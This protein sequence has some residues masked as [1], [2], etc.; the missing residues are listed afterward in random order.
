M[1]PAGEKLAQEIMDKQSIDIDGVSGATVTSK[2]AK[3]A[4]EDCIAQA[5]GI[6]VSLISSEGG[7]NKE[8]AGSADWL[9]EVPVISAADVGKT[10]D[11]EVLV[12][13]A[14]TA[15]LFAAA[16]VE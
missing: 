4:L 5:K 8:E 7:G 15:G 12:I 16:A 3:A 1:P 2:A 9:G 11:T 6:D 14:G 13:G 10:Y